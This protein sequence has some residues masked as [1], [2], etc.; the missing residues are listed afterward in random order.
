MINK[1]F[2]MPNLK[3]S[4]VQ[5]EKVG[6]K[7]LFGLTCFMTN[8]PIANQQLIT[9]DLCKNLM[10]RI[11]YI[12]EILK[13]AGR[14]KEKT[15]YDM[16]SFR[17]SQYKKL[18][19]SDDDYFQWAGIDLEY[20]KTLIQEVEYFICDY[21]MLDLWPKI[22]SVLLT[23]S[24]E[25][26]NIYQRDKDGI[27]EV[28]NV[29]G[30]T[31]FNTNDYYRIEPLIFILEYFARLY[32]HH[33]ERNEHY[34]FTV[35]LSC[36]VGYLSDG[37]NIGF[38]GSGLHLLIDLAYLHT[39]S[40]DSKEFRQCEECHDTWFFADKYKNQRFCTKKCKSKFSSRQTRERKDTAIHLRAEGHT[41]EYIS[42]EIGSDI[43]TIQ[44][45]VMKEGLTNGRL[46]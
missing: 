2:Y 1:I 12:A 30:Y 35:D 46:G 21:G 10:E 26:M 19:I 4:V 39:V 45:W 3:I 36:Q 22:D 32:M 25:E 18:L 6:V 29:W 38:M 8:K 31:D 20:K 15:T 43:Q 17:T 42:R 5:P 13:K 9:D 34:S 28:D 37:H 41:I 7:E 14:F 40:D 24:T 33:T 27:L 44:K 11:F 23:T 16:Y